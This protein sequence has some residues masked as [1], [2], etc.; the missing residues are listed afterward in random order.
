VPRLEKVAI[1][2]SGPAGLAAA[3]DLARRGYQPTV[4]EASSIVGGNLAAAIPEF[5]L[6][7]R[8]LDLEIECIRQ[9]GV[10]I[11]TKTPVGRNPSVDD[12][13]AQGYKAVLLAVGAHQSLRLGLSG[14]ET[15][16]V[17]DGLDFLKAV[18]RGVKVSLGGR[19]GVVG[20]G[21]AA[22][23]A[24]RTALRARAKEV[25][26][27]YRRTK[28]E[29]PAMKREI[30]AGIEEGVAIL[31]LAAPS[32]II[33]EDGRLIGLE[34]RRMELSDYDETGR[35]RPVP[36]PGSEFV[37]PLDT[38]ILAIGEQP[39]L[40]FL[41]VGHGLAISGRNTIQADPE[42][43]TAG[44]P[45]IFATG[46]CVTG[47]STIAD[48]IASGKLAAVSI[49]KYLRGQPVV[50][51]YTVAGPSP[52]IAPVERTTEE[53]ELLRFPMPCASADERVR[54]FGMVELGYSEEMAIL[55]ARRCLRCDL[56]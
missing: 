16:G 32:R 24:A 47:P 48:S 13:F 30:D 40:S 41:P 14:E 51:E 56:R 45:G 2:G 29:M 31:E 6:P 35:R 19:V 4:F 12:L 5:R 26:I 34:C 39:D 22:I 50:R 37:L 8:I 18:K 21:N 52:Y 54:H 55:E 23:D 49:H 7:R 15:P 20:G 27:I 17:R 43:L 42:T 1:V 38:L 25:T 53:V 10:R 28:A 46:D 11:Q 36:I 3:Y 44:R 9:T 33:R